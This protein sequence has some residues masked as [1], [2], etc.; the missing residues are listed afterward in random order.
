MHIS[1]I[2][3]YTMTEYPNFQLLQGLTV[4]S[5]VALKDDRYL[6]AV[7]EG[8]LQVVDIVVKT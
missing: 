3:K 5:M 4:N 7:Q 8:E 2:G 1:V 6:C